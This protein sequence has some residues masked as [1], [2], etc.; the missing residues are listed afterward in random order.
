MEWPVFPLLVLSCPVQD[1]SAIV[2]TNAYCWV[3]I[4]V[5][6]AVRTSPDSR[7]MV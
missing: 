5:S 3:D 4:V 7:K 2:E 6:D 1:L